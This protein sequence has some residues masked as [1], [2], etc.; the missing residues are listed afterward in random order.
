MKIKTIRIL[1][2]VIIFFILF[3]FLVIGN[4][5]RNLSKKMEEEYNIILPIKEFEYD[6]KF[7]TPLSMEQ[8]FKFKNNIYK[9][10][11]KIYHII[12]TYYQMEILKKNFYI[13][14]LN[15]I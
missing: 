12:I 5:K 3:Y 2:L 10:K 6:E 15:Y 7:I 13:N 9:S 14:Y 11:Y 1:I 8:K 4:D